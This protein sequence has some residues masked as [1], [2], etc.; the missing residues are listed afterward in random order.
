MRTKK[1]GSSTRRKGRLTPNIP[2]AGFRADGAR[3]S[4]GGKKRK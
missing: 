4:C 2:R 1:T 3:F